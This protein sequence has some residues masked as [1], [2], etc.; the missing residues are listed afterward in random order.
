MNRRY[1]SLES[2]VESVVYPVLGEYT[3]E[4]DVMAIGEAMTEWVDDHVVERGDRDFWAVVKANT[5]N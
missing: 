2:Y 3:D 1:T 4:Y 5:I